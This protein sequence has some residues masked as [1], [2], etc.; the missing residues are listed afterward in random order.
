MPL[1]R[2]IFLPAALLVLGNTVARA[3]IYAF[4][5]AAGLVHYSNVPA[6]PRYIR[7]IKDSD[8]SDQE[9]TNRTLLT[10]SQLKRRAATF[11]ELIDEEARRAQLKPALLRAV[12]EVES[13]FDPKAVSR[14][15]ALGLMQL[16]PQTAQRYGVRHPF[17]PSENLRAGA[18][19]L[20]DLLRRYDN[21]VEL[22]L[23]AYNAGIEAVDRYGGTIPPYAETRAYVPAVL[24]I[25]RKLSLD[26]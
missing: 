14:K 18:E 21:R 20:K 15:G 25:Y 4:T 2:L 1:I 19:Y 24:S 10:R 26:L 17:D 8:H 13:A 11:T 6:D 23:A 3:D 9:R 22:A 7:I 12:V 16:L 5:D